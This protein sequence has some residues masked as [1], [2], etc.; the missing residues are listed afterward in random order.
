MFSSGEDA[1]EQLQSVGY[2]SDE[3]TGTAVFLAAKLNKPILL[4]GPPGSGK[5]ELAYAIADSLKTC[6][7]RLQCYPGI[8][9]E[10]AI[11]RFDESMQRL[12]VE[13]HARSARV[14]DWETLRTELHELRFFMPGP[15]M[16][17]LQFPRPCVLLID[18][19]DKVPEEFEAM[20]L[21]VLSVWRLSIPKLGTISAKAIPIVLLTSNEEREIGYPLRRRSFYLRIEHPTPEREA[22]IL[23]MKTPEANP[24]FHAGM[25]GLAAA[26]RGWSLEQPLSISEMLDLA[27]ALQLLGKDKITPDMR[28][29]LLPLVAKTKADRKKLLLRDGFASLI[30]DAEQHTMR[31]MEQL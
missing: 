30:Y 11:G 18:E 29:I 25:A 20:L 28:D 13:L 9:D 22:K 15:L 16:R 14:P 23:A 10:K 17:A 5:T 1:K 21:E 3:V 7:E 4:E 6:V 19:I 31:G 27:R 26:L 2:L 12:W 24:E 8:S